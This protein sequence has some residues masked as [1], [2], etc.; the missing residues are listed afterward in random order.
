MSKPNFYPLNLGETLRSIRENLNLS[1]S[2]VSALA[3]VDIGLLSK[4]ERGER[5]FNRPLLA[6]L[7]N[8][9]NCDYEKLLLLY[10]SE[11]FVKEI[12]DNDL[13]LKALVIA[14]QKIKYKKK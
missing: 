14:E 12:G 9:Y 10:W 8:V 5:N 13:A 4:M 3:K 11:K 6:S 1:L 2:E 7:S